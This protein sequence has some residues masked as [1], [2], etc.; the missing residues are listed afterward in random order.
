M[1]QD[2]DSQRVLESIAHT[3]VGISSF[4]HSLILVLRPLRIMAQINHKQNKYQSLIFPDQ[5]QA[6]LKV[7]RLTNV[8]GNKRDLG[9]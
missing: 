2:L 4:P 5:L 6:I 1:Y 9:L 8:P 7:N 3:H